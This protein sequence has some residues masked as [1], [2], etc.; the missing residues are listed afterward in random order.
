MMFLL[1][2]FFL[3]PLIFHRTWQGC[4]SCALAPSSIFTIDVFVVAQR[5]K[6]RRGT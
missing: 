5:Y 3:W 4:A 1:D 2:Y 6:T